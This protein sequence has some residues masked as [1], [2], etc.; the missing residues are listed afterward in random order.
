MRHSRNSSLRAGVDRPAAPRRRLMPRSSP[1]AGAVAVATLVVLALFAFDPPENVSRGP[2]A[3]ET[4]AGLLP[5]AWSADT[6]DVGRLDRATPPP[7]TSSDSQPTGSTVR[8]DA[9]AALS[10]TP[11]VARRSVASPSAPALPGAADPI[12]SKLDSALRVAAAG[13]PAAP[14]RVLVRAAPGARAAVAG[15]IRGG[16]RPVHAD[17]PLVGVLS[18]T[19]PAGELARLASDP[20]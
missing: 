5:A 8:P 18:A 3:L 1:A 17:H 19:V 4:D 9:I 11:P 13:D 2:G 20:V 14:V 6:V 10:D 12:S 16:G 7:P 15:R